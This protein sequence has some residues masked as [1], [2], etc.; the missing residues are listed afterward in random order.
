MIIYDIEKDGILKDK[1]AMNESGNLYQK[2][3]N[4]WT[5]HA[6]DY[7]YKYM[8]VCVWE[9][10]KLW[11]EKKYLLQKSLEESIYKPCCRCNQ[12]ETT[13]LNLN[14]RYF[15]IINIA[16]AQPGHSISANKF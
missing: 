2:K 4:G 14:A 11:L 7:M 13:W 10:E 5:V 15:S 6:L 16:T 9:K 1:K 8:Y 12:L 3:T